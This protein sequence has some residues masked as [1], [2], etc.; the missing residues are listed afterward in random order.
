LNIK[1][2]KHREREKLRMALLPTNQSGSRKFANWK[3]TGGECGCCDKA[4]PNKR[5]G[6]EGKG[7]TVI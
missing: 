1:K 2:S 5:G 7:K 4:G 3:K 6:K